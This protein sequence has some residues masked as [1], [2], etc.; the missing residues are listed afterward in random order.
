MEKSFM[1]LVVGNPD[2]KREYR[3]RKRRAK[4]LPK[5]YRYAYKKIMNYSYNF[6]FSV[7]FGEELLDFFEE[8]SSSG[9]PVL[10]VIGPDAASFCDELMRNTNSQREDSR[11]KLNREVADYFRKKER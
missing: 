9:R 4:A 3:Q 7:K 6:G 8:S 11:E 1:E 5:D 2:E 10:E